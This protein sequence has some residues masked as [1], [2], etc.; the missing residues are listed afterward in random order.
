MDKVGLLLADYCGKVDEQRQKA[1]TGEITVNS[2]TIELERVT[3][4]AE[5]RIKD[6]LEQ[7]D[8]KARIEELNGLQTFYDPNDDYAIYPA[9][10]A[11]VAEL[12]SQRSR[13]KEE[14]K[15]G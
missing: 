5:Q 15:N 13:P 8:I 7:R 9:I 11:R 6:L 3:A 10:E 2:L 1:L 12:E 14:Q 4:E